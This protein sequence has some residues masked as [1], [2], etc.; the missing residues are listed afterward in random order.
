LREIAVDDG[1]ITLVNL[2]E[3]LIEQR[4]I[5]RANMQED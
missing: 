3:Y 5:L 2:D 4:E 1:P